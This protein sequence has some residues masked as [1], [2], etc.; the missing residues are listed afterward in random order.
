M[1]RI[2]LIAELVF[3]RHDLLQ[4]I[5][6]QS[7]L[8]HHILQKRTRAIVG[9]Q[10]G[11]RAR[12]SIRCAQLDLITASIV[13]AQLTPLSRT[14]SS[15]LQIENQLIAG[16]VIVLGILRAFGASAALSVFGASALLS[17]FAASAVI[18][19]FGASRITLPVLGHADL[20]GFERIRGYQMR[21]IIGRLRIT[22]E[23]IDFPYLIF[24]LLIFLIVFRQVRPGMGLLGYSGLIGYSRILD[25]RK[26]V[27]FRPVLTSNSILQP[28]RDAVRAGD[29]GKVSIFP[30]L[31]SRHAD[32]LHGVGDLCPD[33]FDIRVS[34]QAVEGVGHFGRSSAAVPGRVAIPTRAAASDGVLIPTS[35]ASLRGPSGTVGRAG[36]FGRG[37]QTVG[38][39]RF[40]GPHIIIRIRFLHTVVQQR[41][42][43]IDGIVCRFGLVDEQVLPDSLPVIPCCQTL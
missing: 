35:V 10:A 1:I 36:R 11:E 20:Q 13:L 8:F 32:G 26:L 37:G 21:R 15:I 16:E 12:P 17:V 7:Y 40:V 28:K 9:R 42:G 6:G 2:I 38:V 39:G 33:L 31:L 43:I 24:D 27:Q 3:T 23:R 29:V 41:G 18:S 30:Y 5:V 4:L 19:T 14:L 22:L 34:I 25:Q